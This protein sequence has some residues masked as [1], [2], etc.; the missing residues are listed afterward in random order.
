MRKAL[1]IVQLLLFLQ[2]F[3]TAAQAQVSP[4]EQQV[5]REL[6]RRNIDQEELRQ[7]LLAR[8]IDVNNM[9]PAQL[10]A[11]QPIIEQLVAEMEAEQQQT[12]ETTIATDEGQVIETDSII[13]PEVELSEPPQDLPPTDIWGHHIFR[14]RSLQV[15]SAND[16]VKAPG[17]YLL[18]SGDVIA[19]SIYGASQA[20]LKYTIDQEGFIKPY[21]MPR[22]YLRGLQLSKAKTLLET[23]FRQYYSFQAGQ[24][25]LTVDAPRVISVNIFG[26]TETNGSYTISAVN[27]L[28]NALVAAGGPTDNG[29]VRNIKLLRDGKETIVDLYTYLLNPAKQQDLFLA[30]NDIIFVPLANKVIEVEGAVRRP[31]RYELLKTEGLK[32]AIDYAGGPLPVAVTAAITVRRQEGNKEIVIDGN[33][34]KTA[35]DL[36]SSDVVLVPSS[37]NPEKDFVSITGDVSLPGDYAFNPGVRV[38]DILN[39]AGIKRSSRLDAGFLKRVNEDGTSTL[40]PLSYFASLE[41]PENSKLLQS[42]DQLIVFSQATYARPATIAVS[43]AVNTPLSEYPYSA[44]GQITVEDALLLAGGKLSNAS[45]IAFLIRKNPENTEQQQYVR[46]NLSQEAGLRQNLRPFDSLVVYTNNRFSDPFPVAIRGAV[47]QQG[48]YTYDPSLG[49]K[50]L[51]TLAGGLKLEAA[52]NRVD[53][54]RL[55]LSQTEAAQ[56]T[57][58][59][60]E[61]DEN[62]NIIGGTQNFKIQPY[63][64]IVI[65]SVPEF[66]L[67]QSVTVIGEVRYPGDYALDSNNLRLS[68]LVKKAGGL[69]EEAFPPGAVLYRYMEDVGLVVIHLDDVLKDENSVSNITLKD[70]D[71]LR[72]PKAK[73]LVT[74]FPLG[75]Q[76]P[77]YVSDSIYRD[78]TID[79]AF[80]GVHSAKWY[81]DKY[82][83]G[84]A[85]N[86]KRKSLT[87]QYANGELGRTKKFLFF[88]SYPPVRPGSTIRM[89]LKPPRKTRKKRE[90][91]IDW[92]GTTQAVL[93]GITATLTLYLLINRLN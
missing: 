4:Q 63:D 52:R 31:M 74:I 40:I 72:I 68:D 70:G 44:D 35:L 10:A 28:F 92:V 46:V 36:R 59:A 14:N 69:T 39:K 89:D 50:E 66:E 27:T 71:E 20:D 91:P 19:I 93:G 8:G 58:T 48:N 15:I 47:R 82:T 62:F 29:S 30:D 81:V 45:D 83:A 49:L 77:K 60:L 57:T 1:F 75:T 7:R 73:D 11:A 85:D 9:T 32:E 37:R 33:Y 90:E 6:Q 23:R 25:S 80:N 3:P 79:V 41:N 78:G 22:I 67:I 21:K 26:E 16:N 54:F 12:D 51:I 84:F 17:S 43:G 38:A 53:V 24:F 2:L 5:K 55:H 86:A 88:K 65:R 13:V 42:G 76:A 61:I 34:D 56:T 18:G 64:V 87:V